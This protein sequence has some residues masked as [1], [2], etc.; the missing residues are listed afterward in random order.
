MLFQFS[1]FHYKYRRQLRQNN[2]EERVRLNI[3]TPFAAEQCRCVVCGKRQ[4]FFEGIANGLNSG[5]EQVQ[6]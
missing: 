2:F 5:S 3:L 4:Q 6:R 1:K